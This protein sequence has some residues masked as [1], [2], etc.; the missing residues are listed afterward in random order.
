MYFEND[1][2]RED[3]SQFAALKKLE[4][5]KAT[6][7]QLHVD[8]L[9]QSK[10]DS[11]SKSIDDKRALQSAKQYEEDYHE[12]GL[13]SFRDDQRR[14]FATSFGELEEHIRRLEKID[15][16]IIRLHYEWGLNEVEIGNLFN[17]SEGRI[18]QRLKAIQKCLHE[19][20]E[21]KTKDKTEAKRLLEKVLFG[22][23]QE[24]EFREN[25]RLAIFK[26]FKMESYSQKSFGEWD[27]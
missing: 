2:D 23:G 10:G 7:S 9:R 20:I 18:S 12:M 25:K 22:E 19:R 21:K 13:S 16:A 24:M 5:R 11:R 17:V 27:T 6:N 15:Q 8:Y 1:Q 3:F 26:P 14:P 4:G